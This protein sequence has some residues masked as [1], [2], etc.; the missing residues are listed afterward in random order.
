VCWFV[1]AV[2]AGVRNFPGW[3][4]Q[5][6]WCIRW[7]VVDPAVARW[8]WW[9]RGRWNRY[10]NIPRPGSGVLKRWGGKERV[11]CGTGGYR[12]EHISTVMY[13]VPVPLYLGVGAGKNA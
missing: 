12:G 1:P 8:Y 5:E 4:G 10:R 2:L 9:V 13:A 11:G 6:L 3:L 7:G